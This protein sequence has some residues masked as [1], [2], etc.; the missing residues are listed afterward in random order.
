MRRIVAIA[1]AQ[2]SGF[3]VCETDDGLGGQAPD[4]FELA[5]NGERDGG[6]QPPAS[7]V[8]DPFELASMVNQIMRAEPGPTKLFH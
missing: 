1:L 4:P 3:E 6:L 5:S 8:P 2:V 7:C